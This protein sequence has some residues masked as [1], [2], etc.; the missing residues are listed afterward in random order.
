METKKR[1]IK[2][3]NIKNLFKF[4]GWAKEFPWI[5]LTLFIVFAAYGYQS[6]IQQCRG[7]IENTCYQQCRLDELVQEFKR[8]NPNIIVTCSIDNKTKMYDCDFAG[9]SGTGVPFGKEIEDA[10]AQIKNMSLNFSN[11]NQRT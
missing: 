10:I 6:D 8:H 11:E 9:I 3:E 1:I 4:E 2:T 5:L 7:M